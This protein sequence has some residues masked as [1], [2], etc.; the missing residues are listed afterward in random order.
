MYIINLYGAVVAVYIAMM[1]AGYIA[2]SAKKMTPKRR[3]GLV[4]LP[5]WAWGKIDGMKPEMGKGDAEIIRNIV[6]A[7]LYMCTGNICI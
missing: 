3:R 2:L 1:K 5:D 6:L 7:W 4:S